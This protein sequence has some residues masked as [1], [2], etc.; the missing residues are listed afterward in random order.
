M[1]STLLAQVS[2]YNAGAWHPA[3]R[4]ARSYRPSSPDCSIIVLVSAAE[5]FPM[6]PG[7]FAFETHAAE[8]GQ[9]T[10]TFKGYL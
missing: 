7:R 8:I 6:T 10:L 2:G 9:E 4:V 5:P 1:N 3:L